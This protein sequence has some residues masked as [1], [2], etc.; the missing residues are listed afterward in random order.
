MVQINRSRT[1][2]RELANFDA[3]DEREELK[4]GDAGPYAM[5]S[6]YEGKYRGGR[7]EDTCTCDHGLSRV[8]KVA[9]G[10]TSYIRT[11]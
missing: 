3:N 1:Q 6:K 4:S 11:S 5:R 9:G 7:R 2:E 10:K 8:Q